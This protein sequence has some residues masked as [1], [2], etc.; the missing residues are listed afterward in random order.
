VLPLLDSIGAKMSELEE[1]ISD[2]LLEEGRALAEA[3]VEHVLLCFRSQDLRLP[4]S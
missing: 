1:V 3:M 2:Q 4:W